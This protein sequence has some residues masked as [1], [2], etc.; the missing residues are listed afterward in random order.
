MYW[1]KTTA[2]QDENR[3]DLEFRVSCIW[4]FT[5]FMNH[6]EETAFHFHRSSSEWTRRMDTLDINHYN[7]AIM[8]PRASQITS[9]T[10]IY[11][12]AYSGADQRNHQSSASLTFVR[13]IHRWPVNS[14]HKW[15]VTRKMFS[16]DDF[17][18]NEIN[19]SSNNA[20]NIILYGMLALNFSYDA[21][22]HRNSLGQDFSHRNFNGLDVRK[23]H[24]IAD[25]NLLSTETPR[26]CVML[27][28]NVQSLYS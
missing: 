23:T 22:K 24:K 14:P 21:T 28:R 7:D 6:Y 18:M 4:G 17:F 25:L 9:L 3:N 1:A 8:D 2:R 11:S 15:P 26:Y 12:T 16:C 20:S 5:E 19:S 27:Q 13:G 10:I